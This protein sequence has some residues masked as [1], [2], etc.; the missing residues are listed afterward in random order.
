MAGALGIGMLI[1]LIKE[2]IK[3]NSL[4]PVKTAR[5]EG[6]GWVGSNSS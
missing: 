5:I 1:G 2:C 3:E 4:K 6:A